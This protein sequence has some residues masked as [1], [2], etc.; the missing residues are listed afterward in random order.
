MLTRLKQ[1]PTDVNGALF[2]SAA[3]ICVQFG[4]DLKNNIRF[5]FTT[6]RW[7]FTLDLIDGRAFKCNTGNSQL[8][9]NLSTHKGLHEMYFFKSS[10]SKLHA[11]AERLLNKVYLTGYKI[12]IL[13]VHCSRLKSVQIVIRVWLGEVLRTIGQS[14]RINDKWKWMRHVKYI[15]V[16]IKRPLCCGHLGFLQLNPM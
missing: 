5:M 7:A 9:A 10:R 11:S 1:Q 2:Y 14:V 8:L 12:I 3:N 6:L 4:G 13:D 15:F 16:W